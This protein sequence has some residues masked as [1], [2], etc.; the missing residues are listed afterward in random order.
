VA[1]V[2]NVLPFGHVHETQDTAG[3]VNDVHQNPVE[4]YLG[5]YPEHWLFSSARNHAGLD[6]L[7]HVT[8][9]E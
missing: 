2:F 6:G 5:Q 1:V 7:L 8:I 3:I 9:I 4:S